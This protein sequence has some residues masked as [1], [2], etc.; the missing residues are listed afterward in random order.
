M[1]A[2][3]PDAGAFLVLSRSITVPLRQAADG[4]RRIAEGD[5]TSRIHSEGRDEA[6]QLLQALKGMQD[7]LSRVVANVRGN[8]EGVA[9]A[10]TQIAQGNSDLSAR[11]EQQA[12]ALEETAASMEQLSSTVRLNA[13]NAQ[14]ANQLALFAP[15]AT[16]NII[17]DFAVVK[18][19]QLKL[20]EFIA[21]VFHCPNSNCTNSCSCNS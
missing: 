13:D 7:N 21:G 3:L 2:L 20:P 8:A 14:Q 17:E 1:R 15:T 6:A 16:V 10:S 19:H 11:T 18:K 9:S 4:A 12:S 5:L